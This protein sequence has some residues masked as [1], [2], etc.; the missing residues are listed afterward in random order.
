VKEK[1]SKM[2]NKE[3]NNKWKDFI[4]QSGLPLEFEVKK[5]LSD[6]GFWSEYEFSYLRNDENNLEN[7]FSYDI[8][9]TMDIGKHRFNL[10]VEC[11]YRHDSTNWLFIPEEYNESD[12]GIGTTDFRNT[13]DFFYKENYSDFFRILN[14]KTLAPLCSKGIEI[15]TTGHN[16]K[17]ITQAITQLSFGL[18]N[19]VVDAMKIQLNY[20][21]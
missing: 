2:N 11:K 19:K 15:S 13:N 21:D 1:Y 20:E 5:V 6:F 3:S 7:E 10:L 8:D 14:F 17:S 4:L 12:R 18:A 9:S 16:P